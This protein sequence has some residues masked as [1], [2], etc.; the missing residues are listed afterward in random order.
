MNL[1]ENED[2]AQKPQEQLNSQKASPPR[3]PKGWGP[4]MRWKWYR[5]FQQTD[6]RT[7]WR[8]HDAEENAKGRLPDDEGVQLPAIWVA[9]LYTPSTVSGLLKGITDLGWEYG[10]SRSDSITE[11]MRDVREGRQAGVISLGLVSP[12]NAKHFMQ[13]HT[14]TLPAGV[15]AALPALMSLTP[16]LTAFVIVFLFNDG[17]ATSLETPLRAEFTTSVHNDPLLRPWHV[18]RYILLDGPVRLMRHI[19]TPDIIRH[20]SVRGRLREIETNC[21]QWVQARFPGVFASQPNSYAPTAALLVT[22]QVTPFSAEA[23][24]IRAF[25]GITIDRDFDA[26]ECDEWSGVRLA[27]SRGWD[28]KDNRLVFACRRHDAFPNH[29]GYADPTSNWAIAQRVNRD[30]IQPLLSRWAIT[31][32]LDRYHELLSTLR[33]RTAR[34]DK[35]RPIQDLIELRSLARTTLYDIGVCTQEIVEF[36]ESERAYR[37]NT[38]EMSYIREVQGEKLKLLNE[39]RS[40][41]ARR[42]QQ[43]QREATLLQSTLSTSNDLS[44]MIANLRI[45]QF[46]AILTAI[47]VIVA[48][49]AAYTAVTTGP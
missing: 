18:A 26:W 20:K 37:F 22:E 36:T 4:W 10:R 43:V 30:L 21:V 2:S 44:Q 25:G 14:A 34:E 28:E 7:F 45:Q 46:M 48:L 1:A 38:L 39:L 42:A 8:D 33:D 32:L 19:S 13:E 40:S 27:L 3:K 5:E 47:S 31:C 29:I 41:Q 17:I 9:E 49:W 11:W 15:T 23:R 35:H 12:P 6:D 16:S 24:E